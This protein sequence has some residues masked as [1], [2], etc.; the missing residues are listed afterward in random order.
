MAKN[1]TIMGKQTATSYRLTMSDTLEHGKRGVAYVGVSIVNK[2]SLIGG[3]SVIM[4][5]VI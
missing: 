1:L 5:E 4:S 2:G 3:D